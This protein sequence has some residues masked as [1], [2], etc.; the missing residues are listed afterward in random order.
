MEDWAEIRRL[1]M[2]EGLSGRRIA[3]RLGVSRVTVG[4]ALA[5]DTPPRYE[6]KSVRSSI[7]DPYADAMRVLLR[8]YPKMPATV[9]AERVGFNGGRCTTVF[10]QRV[11]EMKAELGMLDPADRLVLGLLHGWVTFDLA[12]FCWPGRMLLCLLRIQKSSVRMSCGWLLPA[13]L[14]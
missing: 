13:S 2:A 11:A 14:G 12:I 10:R 3:Q 7:V 8:E 6:R 9:L 4:R 1:S 5:R